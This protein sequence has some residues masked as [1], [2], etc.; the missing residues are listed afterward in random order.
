MNVFVRYICK[1]LSRDNFED[2]SI[3]FCMCSCVKDSFVLVIPLLFS[4]KDHY[5][6]MVHFFDGHLA[7]RPGSSSS[8]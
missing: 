4:C 1:E 2:L 3:F 8:G 7:V 5:E 6:N